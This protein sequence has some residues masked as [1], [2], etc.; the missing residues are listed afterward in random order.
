MVNSTDQRQAQCVIGQEVARQLVNKAGL[1]Q[2][3]VFYILD[4]IP[5]KLVALC[6]FGLATFLS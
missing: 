3:V 4:R 6:S 2:L 1:I 5:V